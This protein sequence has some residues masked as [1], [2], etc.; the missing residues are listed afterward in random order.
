M[1]KENKI[2][3]ILGALALLIIITW[4]GLFYVQSRNKKLQLREEQ[5]HNILFLNLLKE[6]LKNN[7]FSTERI[8]D[9]FKDKLSSALA[10]VRSTSDVSDDLLIQLAEI[11]ELEELTVVNESNNIIY[12]SYSKGDYPYEIPLLDLQEGEDIIL[13][14]PSLFNSS[15]SVLMYV[16]KD[17][18][19]YYLSSVKEKMISRLLRDISL[20][21]L[22][23]FATE[24]YRDK[25]ELEL[26]EGHI[27]YIVIQD[28]LGIIAATENVTSLSRVDDDETLLKAIETGESVSRILAFDG[29]Q[30][31]ETVLPFFLEDYSFG[32]IRLGTSLQ[33]IEQASKQRDMIMVIF[34]IIFI[35]FL[36]L[37]YMF[38][39]FFMKF[40]RSIYD[41]N[42]ALRFKE[43][44]ALGGEVAHEVKNPLNSINMILQRI[45]KEFTI[46]EN[47]QEYNRM[48]DISSSE[49]DR[50]NNIIERFLNY[51]RILKLKKSS[52][53]INDLLI[54]VEGLF[55]EDLLRSKSKLTIFCDRD[56]SFLMDGEK[57]KQVLINLIKNSLDAFNSDSQG[58]EILI[59]AERNKN[60]L[61]ITIQ[62]N[63]IGIKKE[64]IENIWDLYFTT[65]EEG[66][67]I[68]LTLS[69]KIVEA[70]NGSID[71][72]S[73]Y[74]EG[75]KFIITIPE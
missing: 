53:N 18:D 9:L 28:S 29:I 20:N 55:K 36:L 11:L 13:N 68:G 1:K 59:N 56:L 69:R 40:K 58:N 45:K 46:T 67:G 37:E 27:K 63:G 48:L 42:K 44:A 52:V 54:S 6:S 74:G 5:Y 23:D 17:R 61:I 30:I 49:L 71:V 8:E 10:I 47:Q 35:L 25:L 66:S 60:L 72:F 15:E 57:I 64:I 38:F 19:Y 32:V 24:S 12:S 14:L 26:D 4:I 70:H 39:L 21:S 51:S 7:I 16:F 65:R 33:R 73:E 41:L 50:L 3:I 43:I 62:D 2:K 75:S 22:I 31:N 34:S